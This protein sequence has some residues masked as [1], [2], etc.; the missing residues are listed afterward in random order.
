MS[1]SWEGGSTRA[2]RL[3]R[4]NILAAN[5]M[6]N[7]GLCCA[8]IPSVCTGV[9]EEV[10]HTRGKAYGDNPRYLQ[11]VCKACNLKIGQPG[12]ISPEPKRVSNW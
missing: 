5:R 8:Q 9:A 7:R 2:W 6:N 3:L 4:A 12:R 11:P 10:H 1:R